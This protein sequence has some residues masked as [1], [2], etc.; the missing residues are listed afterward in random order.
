V[1]AEHE[2]TNAELARRL[3]HVSREVHTDLTEIM[4]RMDSYVLREVYASDQQR[5][6]DQ[7]QAVNRELERIRGQVRW[8]WSAVVMPILALVISVWMQAGGG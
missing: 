7:V 5:R 6:E 1:A 8:L 2:V 3:E 4:R